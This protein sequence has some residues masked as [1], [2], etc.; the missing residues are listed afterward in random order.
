MADLFFNSKIDLNIDRLI[1][2]FC[3]PVK[4][5]LGIGLKGIALLHV[6]ECCCYLHTY[7]L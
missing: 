7:L 3:Y 1:N 6:P 2:I 5:F 4:L